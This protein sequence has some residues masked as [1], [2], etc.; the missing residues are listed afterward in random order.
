MTREDI[1]TCV[2]IGAAVATILALLGG[3]IAYAL[4][5]LDVGVREA[6]TRCESRTASDLSH[7]RA[8]QLNAYILYVNA[9]TNLLEIDLG[10]DVRP[11]DG[12]GP[13]MI[14]SVEEHKRD[15]FWAEVMSL[16]VRAKELQE[17]AENCPNYG[18]ILQ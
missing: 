5:T 7:A 13:E 6:T 2:K 10:K 15:E 18:G 8:L 12:N 1:H 16:E 9:K 3:P 14:R 4:Y 17:N 11:N